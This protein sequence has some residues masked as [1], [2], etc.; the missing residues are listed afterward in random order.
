MDSRSRRPATEFEVAQFGDGSEVAQSGD[1]LDVAQSVAP[2][3]ALREPRSGLGL[4]RE[5]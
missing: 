2:R 4:Q 3:L 5:R 1:G